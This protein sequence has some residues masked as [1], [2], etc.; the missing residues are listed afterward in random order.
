MSGEGLKEVRQAAATTSPLPKEETAGKVRVLYGVHALSV[1]VAGKAVNDV[2]EALGQAMN[3]SPRAIALVDGEEVSESYILIPGQH[4]EFVRQ[5]GE[6]GAP[7][8]ADGA[9]LSNCSKRI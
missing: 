1:H 5:A 4:L 7:G 6:K 9:S 3:I 2:R 8:A